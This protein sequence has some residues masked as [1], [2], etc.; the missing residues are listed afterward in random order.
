MKTTAT[1]QNIAAVFINGNGILRNTAGVSI[2]SGII[3]RRECS[4]QRF[5]FISLA[6]YSYMLDVFC[7]RYR[8]KKYHCIFYVTHFT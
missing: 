3:L 8:A 4:S 6:V 7:R 5:G 1:F 2:N